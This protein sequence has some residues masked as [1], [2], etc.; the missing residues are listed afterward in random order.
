MSNWELLSTDLCIRRRIFF[1][2]EQLVQE[3]KN[4]IF[5]T[6]SNSISSSSMG[7]IESSHQLFAA[8]GKMLNH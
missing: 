7:N 3:E 1:G 6:G 4:G 5:S 8:T 2:C